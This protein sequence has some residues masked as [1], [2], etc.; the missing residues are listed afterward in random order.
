MLA[1]NA[2]NLFVL[3]YAL[4]EQIGSPCERILIYEKGVNADFILANKSGYDI[5]SDC[6][7]WLYDMNRVLYYEVLDD[8]LD[9]VCICGP[10]D[11]ISHQQFFKASKI[12]ECVFST[13][14]T[15]TVELLNDKLE[16]VRVA[17][18]TPE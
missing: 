4:S 16:T 11:Q 8:D 15:V 5:K 10:D 9:E 6:G 7:T 12:C 13:Q 17:H 1:A 3:K 14:K 2:Y 18:V